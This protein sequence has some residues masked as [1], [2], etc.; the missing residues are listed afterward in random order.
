A[1]S[2][3]PSASSCCSPGCGFWSACCDRAVLGTAAQ[4]QL[5]A[6]HFPTIQPVE[7][8]HTQQIVLQLPGLR[9]QRGDGTFGQAADGEPVER[10]RRGARQAIRGLDVDGII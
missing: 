7:E 10:N 1:S 6:A 5:V 2:R 9:D 3:S 8:A 4:A